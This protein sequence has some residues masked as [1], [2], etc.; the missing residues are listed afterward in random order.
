MKFHA[1][2]ARIVFLLYLA[3]VLT[4]LAQEQENRANTNGAERITRKYPDQ[5]QKQAASQL[6][7]PNEGLAILGVALDSRHHRAESFADCSHFV[8]G[9]YE[10]AG[11]PFEYA[12]SSDL[13]QGTAEFRRVT[14]PQTGDL[15][16]WRGHAGIVINPAQHSFFSVLH[17]G[18]GVDLYDSPYWK[19]RGQ[20]RF[21]RYIKQTPGGVLDSSIRTTSLQSTSLNSADPD[22]P[23]AEDAPPASLEEG[24]IGILAAPLIVNSVRPKPTQVEE[25]FLQACTGSEAALRGRELFK[26]G[27]VLIVFD[28]FTVKKVHISGNQG[29][30]E[31]Q[32]DELASFTGGKTEL[33]RR[34]EHQRWSLTRNSNKAWTLIPSPGAVYVSPQAAQRILI[35]EL[36]QISENTPDNAV[37]TRQMADLA[38][39][40]DVL[41]VK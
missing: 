17:A 32:I 21:F 30:A 8:H 26:F 4:G 24:P 33:R 28:R 39:L 38:Q 25:T 18:P 9:L 11:F 6:L 23:M 5:Q 2:K 20:P 29:W 19:R 7:T 1:Q 3:T 16:V 36:G 15:A 13:Y 35:R 12:S 14:N 37:K 41:F 31:V 22:E 40:L 10:R 27:Q 34:S